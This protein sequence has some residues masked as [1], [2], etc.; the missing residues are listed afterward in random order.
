MRRG[1]LYRDFGK[2]WEKIEDL[3]EKLD[4]VY[5]PKANRKRWWKFWR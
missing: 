1:T 4:E 2:G 3:S 5:K